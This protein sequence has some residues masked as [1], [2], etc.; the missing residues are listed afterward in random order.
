MLLSRPVTW[1]LILF[2]ANSARIAFD[3]DNLPKLLSWARG[4]KCLRRCLIGAEEIGSPRLMVLR[5]VAW[6]WYSVELT[7]LAYRT[8]TCFQITLGVNERLSISTCT[9]ARRMYF[10]VREWRSSRARG[11]GVEST[12]PKRRYTGVRDSEGTLVSLSK[13]FHTSAILLHL[14][15]CMMRSGSRRQH[16]Q[17]LDGAFGLMVRVKRALCS[18]SLKWDAQSRGVRTLLLYFSATACQ[19]TGPSSFSHALMHE[20]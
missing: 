9:I 10:Q 16:L 15:R 13:Y 19:C 3:H 1:T 6:A 17:L 4:Y 11:S 18:M 2:A 7:A 5:T 12:T 14:A 8:N 20:G